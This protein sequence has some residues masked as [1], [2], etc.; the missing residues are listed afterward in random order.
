M[1]LCVSVQRHS[2]AT[3][4]A[5]SALDATDEYLDIFD[6]TWP[7]SV[8]SASVWVPV[9][10][11]ACNSSSTKT[12]FPSPVDICPKWSPWF[13]FVLLSF[14]LTIGSV[15][16]HQIAHSIKPWCISSTQARME[17][18][19]TKKT[20]RLKKRGAGKKNECVTPKRQRHRVQSHIE[21]DYPTA[22]LKKRKNWK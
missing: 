20:N 7:A 2:N 11:N 19:K 14:N 6:V 5:R 9:P 21:T 1:C 8:E 22:I 12:S 17:K 18:T 13:A 15:Q 4:P 3:V 16:L 10:A